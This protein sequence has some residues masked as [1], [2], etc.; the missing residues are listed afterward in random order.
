MQSSFQEAAGV[1]SERTFGVICV[2]AMT[3]V[4]QNKRGQ[5][6][7]KGRSENAQCLET[8]DKHVCSDV[9]DAT[10]KL[11]H[12]GVQSSFFCH[13]GLPKLGDKGMNFAQI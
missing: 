11:C 10:S 1:K 3:L 5:V 9:T 12:S 7:T 2:S 4:H 8:T 6:A 13:T